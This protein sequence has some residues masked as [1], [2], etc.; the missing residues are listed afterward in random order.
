[1]GGLGMHCA[2]PPDYFSLGLTPIQFHPLNVAP[3]INLAKVTDQGLCYCYS[4]AWGWHNSHQSGIIIITDY[5]IFQNGK[6]APKCTGGTI[7]GSKTLPCGPPDTTLTS[8]LRQP[9]T[10]T[11]C[12]RFDR[13]CVNIDRTEPAIPT[14]VKVKYSMARSL[15]VENLL[16]QNVGSIINYLL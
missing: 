8:L 5:L 11:C 6:K 15:P 10:I 4:D 2:R 12:D 3:L 9:S 7:T 14:E 1:M 16:P 13:H